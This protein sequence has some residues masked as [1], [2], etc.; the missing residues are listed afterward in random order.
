MSQ[1]GS[2]ALT[3]SQFAF[4]AGMDQNADPRLIDPPKVIAALNVRILKPGSY[5]KR[6][7]TA[8][9]RSTITGP[10]W[11]TGI[12]LVGN[13]VAVLS[14][15][16]DTL[17]H[18]SQR[19]ISART[20][21]RTDL[22]FRGWSPVGMPRARVVWNEGGVP[23]TTGRSQITQIDIATGTTAAGQDVVA[24]AYYCEAADV[25]RLILFDKATWSPITLTIT[26]GT[27]DPVVEYASKH[28]PRLMWMAN[29]L[30]LCLLDAAAN[31]IELR[32]VTTS[33]WTEA[34][35]GLP[36]NATARAVGLRTFYD[37]AIVDQSTTEFVIA[38][39]TTANALN[40]RNVTASTVT[41]NYTTTSA[42]PAAAL[43]AIGVSAT[44]G[45]SV[46]VTYVVN[47][48]GQTRITCF[49]ESTGAERASFPMNGPVVAQ[50]R[51]LASAS[52][53]QS[54]TEAICMWSDVGT[55]GTLADQA[56]LRCVTA[57]T[58][59]TIGTLTTNMQ[60]MIAG[61]PFT[62]GSRFFVP[63][64]YG[65]AGQSLGY[66]FD[67]SG[68]QWS[69]GLLEYLHTRPAGTSW[70]MIH[71][72]M[73]IPSTAG[74]LNMQ[75]VQAGA[76]SA[77]A[78]CST[79]ANSAGEWFHAWTDLAGSAGA[80]G[81]RENLV[82]I[83]YDPSA[84]AHLK[85][86]RLGG[87]AYAAGLVFEPQSVHEHG[88]LHRP[89]V[90]A[91]SNGGAGSVANGTYQYRAIYTTTTRGGRVIRS[92][93]SN[94]ASHTVGAGPNAVTILVPNPT[95]VL[96][97]APHAYASAQ[98]FAEVYRST[99]GL[100][101]PY[102]LVGRAP[103]LVGG[104]FT[105]VT[106]VYA[107]STIANYPQLYTGDVATQ[108]SANANVCAPTYVHTATHKGRVFGIWPDRRTVGFTSLLV[109]NELA[110]AHNEFTLAVD[111]DLVAL[112]S[113]DDVLY[114]FSA[115]AVY[116]LFGEGPSDRFG[117]ISDYQ[118]FQR[119]ASDVGCSDAGSLC[120]TPDGIVFRSAVGLCLLT[121]GG[122]VVP[123][124]LEVQ[125]ELAANTSR[126]SI[127]LHPSQRWLYVCCD[128]GST[129]VRLVFDY[130]VKVWTKDTVRAS[131]ASSRLVSQL[132]LGGT[133]YQTDGSNGYV[134]TEDPSTYL[135][136][137]ST[138]VTQSAQLAAFK[139]NGP[140]GFQG[141]TSFHLLGERHTAHGLTITI[142]YDHGTATTET[143]TLTDAETTAFVTSPI[144]QLIRALT[145]RKSQAAKVTISD[146]APSAAAGTGRGATWIAYGFEAENKKAHYPV[147]AAQQ[148]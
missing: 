103:I 2:P 58:S 130:K 101:G 137:S 6:Y 148:R 67:G 23:S 22:Q 5:S 140:Q 79:V 109:T 1:N 82:V 52:V 9:D 83:S 94:A 119:V 16:G 21:A 18:A 33:T 69:I 44:S 95:S 50:N 108:R 100:S 30:Y 90:I 147:P 104:T 65:G 66:S 14:A 117:E 32:K 123:F 76:G 115:T 114:A 128:N 132:A 62:Q 64:I 27:A 84:G 138:W 13:S 71:N 93:P 78:P 12:A 11:L 36:V 74:T 68:T 19:F 60:T 3:F 107:D 145:T 24:V 112:G 38:Y 29:N 81:M 42:E 51:P 59:A 136:V 43:E 7:G 54:S 34:Y 97:Q 106:D 37:V 20:S 139:A 105:T 98:T 61:K 49:N 75:Y 70:P 56:Q 143:L 126:T 96:A 92:A 8:L 77:F 4:G 28:S 125:D 10:S 31:S 63:V 134:Y 146:V 129:G 133:L 122:G 141:V 45:E 86:A 135:D 131:A 80:T 144:E 85:A 72:A 118:G 40:I 88:F 99:N 57:T 53:R 127:A 111:D 121:R 102:Y 47:A 116:R 17:Y 91:V 89:E 55:G 15:V 87:A 142:D 110:H 26:G 73:V 25:T 46:W 124:G 113:M 120:L 48:S 41:T 35:L 39:Q